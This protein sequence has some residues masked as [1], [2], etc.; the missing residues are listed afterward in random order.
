M[1]AK[2]GG[3]HLLSY[4]GVQIFLNRAGNHYLV[5]YNCPTCRDSLLSLLLSTYTL[6]S[7]HNFLVATGTRGFNQ[8]NNIYKIRCPA[9]W[10]DWILY[11]W[12][13]LI[14]HWSSPKFAL[15]LLLL[16]VEYYLPSPYSLI[17]TVLTRERARLLMLIGLVL[18]DLFLAFLS[19][20]GPIR[21][22]EWI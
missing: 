5:H 4:S 19:L 1:Y 7:I 14:K 6:H 15:S 17:D 16:S 2:T 3:G 20:R 10:A 13:R 11:G 8:Y 18:M 12:V 21:N 9:T 22:A